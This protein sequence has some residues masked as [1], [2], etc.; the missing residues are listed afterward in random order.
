MQQEHIKQVRSIVEEL[1]SSTRE[2]NIYV[3]HK[4][5]AVDS[6][7]SSS[8]Y[9]VATSPTR[10]VSICYGYDIGFTKWHELKGC[11]LLL[12]E[13]HNPDS[14]DCYEKL[15]LSIDLDTMELTKLDIKIKD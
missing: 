9:V 11:T 14:D 7:F 1:Q 3:S 12:S 13:I 8:E 6:S 15:F 5:I 2:Y 10:L 4:S